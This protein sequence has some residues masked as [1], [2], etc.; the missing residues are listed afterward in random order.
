MS[1]LPRGSVTLLFSD[2]EGSTALLKRLGPAYT[3]ALDGHRD[4]LRAAWADHGGTE[5][6]TEG[7]SFFVAFGDPFDAVA[8]AT[9]GQ[10]DLAAHGWP[11]GDQVRVRMGIHTGTPAVHAG[12]YVGMDVHRAARIAAAAHGGQIVISSLTAELVRGSLPDGVSLRDLGG[13]QLKDL[14]APEHL[15]QVS[16]EGL[17]STFPPLKSLGAASNLP[18]S[19]TPLLGR[20]AELATLC[21]LLRSGTARLVTLTGPGGVGKT[22]LGTALA[23]QLVA[24]FP[25]G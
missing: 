25:D 18:R 13:H 3:E 16:V 1:E 4:V 20:K 10:R 5:L 2:I 21:E 24:R 17:L 19:A 14:P 23:Q 15:Y 12:G 11:A 6:G 8:A 9:Q 22:R 7:D